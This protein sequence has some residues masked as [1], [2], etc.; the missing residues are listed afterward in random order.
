MSDSRRMEKTFHMIMN[1][2][3]KTGQ[4]RNKESFRCL[5]W[6]KLFLSVSLGDAW[7][8]IMFSKCGNI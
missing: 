8:P 3:V 5:T 7:T 1:R 6:L 4:A 2:M